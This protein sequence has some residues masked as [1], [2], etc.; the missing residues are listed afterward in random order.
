MSAADETAP[1]PAVRVVRGNPSDEELAAL[2]TVLAAASSASAPAPE[3]VLDTW[4]HPTRLHRDLRAFSPFAFGSGI[5]RPP[6]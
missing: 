3:P 1:A 5:A 2:M 6:R 4:G